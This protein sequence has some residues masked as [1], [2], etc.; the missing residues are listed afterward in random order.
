GGRWWASYPCAEGSPAGRGCRVRARCIRGRSA[1]RCR[2]G[3][4][5]PPSGL[6]PTCGPTAVSPATP[7]LVARPPLAGRSCPRSFLRAAPEREEEKGR[8]GEGETGRRGEKETEENE[9][10]ACADG[11]GGGRSRVRCGPASR[12]VSPLLP[13][14]PSPVLATAIRG[15]AP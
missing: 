9:A 11:L 15:P 6:Q 10:V 8:Q 13:V 3:R 7:I 14:S 12:R 4:P 5:G 1:T 2:A